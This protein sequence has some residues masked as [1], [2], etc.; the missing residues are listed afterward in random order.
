MTS[1]CFFRTFFV[2]AHAL[3]LGFRGGIYFSFFEIVRVIGPQPHPAA[4]KLARNTT[5][6]HTTHK[7]GHGVFCTACSKN[8][9][10]YTPDGKIHCYVLVRKYW[11]KHRGFAYHIIFTRRLEIPAFHS[12]NR[13]IA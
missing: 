11:S 2:G 4:T 8:I 6:S 9:S 1:T 5:K 12:Y 13:L 7:L 10:H 3:F